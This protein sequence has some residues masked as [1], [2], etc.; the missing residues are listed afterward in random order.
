MTK[1]TTTAS[2]NPEM[3]KADEIEET[4]EAKA[5]EAS[6]AKS[7]APKLTMEV[8]RERDLARHIEETE[9][10]QEEAET[11][12]LEVIFRPFTKSDADSLYFLEQACYPPPYRMSYSQMVTTL[13]DRDTACLVATV[14][15][16]G[17][18]R[19]V[20]ALIVKGEHWH[21]ALVVLTLIV[22]PDLRR[23]ALGSRMLAWAETMAQN[24]N[25]TRLL[26]PLEANRS[27]GEAFLKSR[28][29]EPATKENP[30]FKDPALG[31][32]WEKELVKE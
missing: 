18:E 5:D 11:G 22:R 20:A 16:K 26:V 23:K 3:P 17:K 27:E 21:S 28:Q 24:H 14:L 4:A 13:L 8:L 7:V 12:P 1:K 2:K 6:E 19:V 31:Q 10:P 15:D 32:L 29:L 9:G 30:F 25:I